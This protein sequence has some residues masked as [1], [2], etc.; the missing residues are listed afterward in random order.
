MQATSSDDFVF[1]VQS[2]KC[3][4][5]N[6]L[7]SKLAEEIS[8]AEDEL[9]AEACRIT[10]LTDFGDDAFRRPL[11][12]LLDSFEEDARLN[13]IGRL[14]TRKELI[15]KLT[16]R[17]LMQDDFKRHPEILE[18]SI[19]RPIIIAGLARTGT[20][21]LHH[22]MAQDPDTR[23]LQYWEL[24]FPS[25][26]P[27]IRS[28]ET[29]P[30]RKSVQRGSMIWNWLILSKRGS[31]QLSRMHSGNYNS[32]EECWPLFQNT[33]LSNMF[34]NF[35]RLKAYYEWI[36]NQDMYGAYLYYIKQLQLL[37]WRYSGKR[38]ILKHPGHLN[39]LETLIRVFPDALVIWTH[40]DP[41]K[42]I[43]S[44]C[45]F[46]TFFRQTRSDQVDLKEIGND[47]L[48]SAAC[49]VNRGMKVRES[50]DPA[51]FYDVDY[52]AMIKDPI[53]E[54]RQIYKF[55]GDDLSDQSLNRMKA[56]LAVNPRNKYG[57]HR[58]RLETFEHDSSEV[59]RRFESYRERFSVPFE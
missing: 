7:G 23:S 6:R 50:Y 44:S 51:R 57:I 28:Y 40:R 3:R 17:L 11:R 10:Q 56:W 24:L 52:Y 49:M 31:N 47:V 54:V 4:M 42:I 46:C 34:F 18:V 37:L 14:L 30:R 55:I 15:Q 2:W 1:Q 9:L 8:L 20:T 53:G 32:P 59:N 5:V 16:N 38:L 58:Y 48:N 13:Y 25:P 36:Q 41:L 22:L 39:Y 27:D 21:F 33:F 12:V 19:K 35:A 45:S 29:D 26:P 43:P